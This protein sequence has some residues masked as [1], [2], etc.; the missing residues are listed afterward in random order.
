MFEANSEAIELRIKTMSYVLRDAD[1][2]EIVGLSANA[3]DDVKQDYAAMIAEMESDEP[4][5]K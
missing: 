5:L 3:P 4:M 2:D 1:T